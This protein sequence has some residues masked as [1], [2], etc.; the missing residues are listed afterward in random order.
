MDGNDIAGSRHPHLFSPKLSPSYQFRIRSAHG[1]AQERYGV[2]LVISSLL[3]WMSL[4]DFGLAGNP[5]VNVIAEASGKDDRQLE[6]QYS[7]SAFWALAA[8]SIALGVTFL[9]AFHLVPWRSVFQVCAAVRT[10]ELEQACAITLALFVFGLPLNM[11]ASVY[12]AYQDGFV[13]NI[14]SI[15]S[16]ALALISLILVT[17]IRGGLPLLVIALSGTR[18]SI[19]MANGVYAFARRYPWLSPQPSAVRWLCVKRLLTLGGKYK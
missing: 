11:V 5:L 19:V 17:Q 6:Q 8:I 18:M 13:S 3:T 4:T 12:N 1:S 15:A 7:A 9:G 10:Q 16:N 14:W 2:W